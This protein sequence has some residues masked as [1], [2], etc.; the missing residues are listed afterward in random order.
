MKSKIF[1]LFIAATFAFTP[2]RAPAQ[3]CAGALIVSAL[4]VN[5]TQHRELTEKEAAT[6]GLIVD[7]SKPTPA[8][9]PAPATNTT[10]KKDN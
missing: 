4:I 1:A 10:K 9:K 3:V 6:C 2:T 5:A 8:A 7:T